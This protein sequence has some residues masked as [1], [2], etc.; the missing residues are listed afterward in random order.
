LATD[1][2]FSGSDI[3]AGDARMGATRSARR[4]R[5]RRVDG[6]RLDDEVSVAGMWQGNE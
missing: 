4:S 2:S 1:S 3:V 6:C 5:Q